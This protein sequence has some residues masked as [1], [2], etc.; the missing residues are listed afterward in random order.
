MPQFA[1][2]GLTTPFVPQALIRT[3]FNVSWVIVQRLAE[4]VLFACISTVRE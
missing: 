1:E 4:P 3:F 2:Y